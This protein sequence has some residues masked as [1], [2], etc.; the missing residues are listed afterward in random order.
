MHASY[1]IL[2]QNT[3]LGCNF[4]NELFS[5]SLSLCTHSY[6]CANQSIRWVLHTNWDW[7]MHTCMCAFTES[8]HM[9]WRPQG[10]ECVLKSCSAAAWAHHSSLLPLLLHRH[11]TTTTTTSHPSP[12]SPLHKLMQHAPS[13]FSR[14]ALWRDAKEYVIKSRI[15][16]KKKKKG[17]K[18]DRGFVSYWAFAVPHWSQRAEQSTGSTYFGSS[19]IIHMGDVTETWPSFLAYAS[20]FVLVLYPHSLSETSLNTPNMKRTPSLVGAILEH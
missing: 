10:A 11:P 12:R 14:Q 8:V 2:Q 5:F 20:V 15:T 18:R 1:L 13:L 9:A 3:K 19:L 16:V 7:C 17:T 4:N 6:L